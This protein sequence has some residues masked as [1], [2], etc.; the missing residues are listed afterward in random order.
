MLAAQGGVCCLCS[1]PPTSKRR[2]AVDH[3]HA[4]GVVRGL[5]CH[6]CNR[7]LGHVN[8]SPAMLRAMAEYLEKGL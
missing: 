6:P 2:L 4:T 1:R 8:D 7:F 5:L 3:N